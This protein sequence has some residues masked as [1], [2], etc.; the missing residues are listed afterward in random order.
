MM[1]LR[2]YGRMVVGLLALW[3]GLITAPVR[4]AEP[5]LLVFGDSLSAGYGIAAQ[6]A[7]PRL[8]DQTLKQQGKPYRVVNASVSG[9]TTAGGRTRFPAALKQH[10]PTIVVIELGANDGLRGLP[11]KT[12]RA[13]LAAMIEAAQRSGA[14]VHLVGMQM[15]P[16][17][18]PDYTAEFAAAY[19]DLARRYRTGFTPFLL[20]PV[21]ARPDLFQNDRLH[22]TAEAQPL[23]AR[24]L[25]RDLAPLL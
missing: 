5:V 6:A 10:K 9:E 8:L 3:L 20:A 2:G 1:G 7:W 4:A 11:V 19:A 22:P 25:A 23:L 13:N 24:M 17:Y 21:I 18:G 15:P 16:N 12:A 14:K